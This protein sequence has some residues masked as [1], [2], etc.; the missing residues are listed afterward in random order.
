MCCLRSG[1]PGEN[2]NITKLYTDN[3]LIIYERSDMEYAR[4]LSK[5]GVE[6]FATAVDSFKKGLDDIPTRPEA[7]DLFHLLNPA[8]QT[9]QGPG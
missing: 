4:E 3:T 7:H 8:F 9:V 5:L 1:Y 2:L 6:P